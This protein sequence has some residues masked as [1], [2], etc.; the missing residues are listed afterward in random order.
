MNYKH[1]HKQLQCGLIHPFIFIFSL[2]I[3]SFSSYS[4]GLAAYPSRIFFKT[5]PAGNDSEKLTVLNTGKSRLELGISVS[6]W[7]YDSL[8]NN[9]I[10]DAGTLNTSAA[11]WIDIYPASYL[12]LEPGERTDLTVNMNVPGNPDRSV[13]V[14][15]AMIFLTQLNTQSVQSANGAS[16]QVNIRSGIKVYHSL[17]NNETIDVDVINFRRVKS[18]EADS[19]T[20]LEL[21]LVMK[22]EMWLEGDITTMIMNMQ[23]GE[24][25]N[26]P[27]IRYYAL[28]GDK[29][30]V[31]IQI[32]YKLKP[33]RYTATS[34]VRYGKRDE[35]KVA[36]LE[37]S[38]P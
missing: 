35:I 17:S 15:T 2:I 26:I 3:S 36:E 33:G 24:M 30:H 1:Y 38:I 16:I 12:V 32:P 4:Q 11:E 20:N 8:G 27:E 13:T 34:Q 31:R 37:F 5:S 14:R 22:G 29:R 10:S 9:V 21:T 25:N 23:T 19:L 7:E 28:P 18:E 6:D